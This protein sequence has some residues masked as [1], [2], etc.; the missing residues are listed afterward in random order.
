MAGT[1]SATKFLDDPDFDTWEAHFSHDGRWVTFDA[2]QKS[3]SSRIYVVPFRKAVLPRSEWIAITEGGS[4]DK[5][6]FSY[7]GKL[8]FF[9]SNRDGSRR[10]WAQRLGSDMRPDG[11]PVAVYPLGQSKLGPAISDDEI[12]VG[13]QR[14]VFTQVEEMSNIWLLEPAKRDIH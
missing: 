2:T 3:K 6:R 13:P 7:D 10:L 8:I 4:G 1:L 9:R 5:P 12:G 11:K 14:I